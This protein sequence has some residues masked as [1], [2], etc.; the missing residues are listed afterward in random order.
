MKAE[1]LTTKIWDN[2]AW[3]GDG[4]PPTIQES[5]RIE[6]DLII[7]NDQTIKALGITIDGGTI[8][9][10]NGGIRYSLQT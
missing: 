1:L 7:A 6:D 10:K 2:N 5:A 4:N 8:T 9:I 3:S